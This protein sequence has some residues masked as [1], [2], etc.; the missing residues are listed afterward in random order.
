MTRFQRIKLGLKLTAK[1]ALQRRWALVRLGARCVKRDIKN[2]L[3]GKLRPN[4]VVEEAEVEDTGCRYSDGT[5]LFYEVIA[6]SNFNNQQYVSHNQ[7]E[8]VTTFNATIAKLEFK[9]LSN[10]HMDVEHRTFLVSQQDHDN[11][12]LLKTIMGVAS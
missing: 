1:S 9:R 8:R 3:S 5:R 6:R 12:Q 2:I 7:T 10:M 11:P 4:R